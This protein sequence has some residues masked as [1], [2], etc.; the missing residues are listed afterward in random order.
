MMNAPSAVRGP[1]NIGNPGE[2]AR[3]LA[4][5]DRIDGEPFLASYSS[6]SPP[7]P[8]QRQPDISNA[9]DLLAW[10]AKFQLRDGVER[11]TC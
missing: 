10:P 2:S 4:E 8:K 7:S 9:K 11:F 3:E 1:V 6:V 5:L